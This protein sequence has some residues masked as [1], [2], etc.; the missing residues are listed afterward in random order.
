MA[1]RTVIRDQKAESSVGAAFGSPHDLIH[2]V[3]YNGPPKAAPTVY[4]GYMWMYVCQWDVGTP[5]V[6]IHIYIIYADGESPSLQG[7]RVTGN[8][9]N[10][11]IQTVPG[12]GHNNYHLFINSELTKKVI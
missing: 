6:F 4:Q 10:T 7:I 1:V 3:I 9:T 5:S 12:R 11:H 8:C 2:T